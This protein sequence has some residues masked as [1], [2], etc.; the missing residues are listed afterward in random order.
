[1]LTN[2]K[3]DYCKTVQVMYASGHVSR[4]VFLPC[5][6]QRVKKMRYSDSWI[7]LWVHQIELGSSRMLTNTKFGSSKLFKSCMLA[8][9]QLDSWGFLWSENRSRHEYARVACLK[10]RFCHCGADVA[11]Q[12]VGHVSRVVLLPCLGQS[13]N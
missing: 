2:T 10:T 4:V 11:W 1:M 13:V 7:L 6:G 9:S 3:F 8:A 5:S 12:A